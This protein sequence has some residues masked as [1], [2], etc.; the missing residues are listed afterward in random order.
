M[1]I[2]KDSVVSGSLRV[3]E[4]VLTNE[5]HAKIINIPTASDGS[6]LGPG[7]NGQVIKSNGTSAYWA[8]DTN[9]NTHRPIQ[10]N[11]TQILGDNT[12]ALNIASGSNVSL[13][14]SGGTVTIAASDTKVTSVGNHYTPTTNNDST[15]TANA[16]G[17]T[18]SWGI[19]VVKGVTINRDAKGHVTNVS[20]TS[21]KIP[22]AYAAI[23]DEEIDALFA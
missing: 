2:L 7:T 13:S 12:T 17:A 16:S 23:S 14:N 8:S 22:A 19:D 15:L 21:G 5:I 9:T 6:T 18:A 1:A 3:T 10:V 20:V 4:E 11:G